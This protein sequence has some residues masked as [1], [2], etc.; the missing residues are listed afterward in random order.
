MLANK[1]FFS[2]ILH[3]HLSLL[4]FSLITWGN[5][6]PTSLQP[7]ITLQKKGVRITNLSDFKSHSS[8]LFCKLGLHKLGIYIVIYLD[9]IALFIRNY[10]SNR[11]PSTFN[12]FFKSINK[13]HQYATRLA[14]KKSYYL[15]KAS[16]NYG[17][18]NICFSGAKLWNTIKEDLKSASHFRFKKLL[19]ESVISEY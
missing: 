10:Y 11:L 19:K 1:S 13:V 3:S 9:S 5:T 6:Y 12:N 17:K 16:T 2:V 8:P 4:D 7:L 15:P 14:S 18:F